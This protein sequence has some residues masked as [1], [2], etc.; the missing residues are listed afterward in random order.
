MYPIQMQSGKRGIGMGYEG[1]VKAFASVC[2]EHQREGRARA[3]AFV[4]Y[5]MNQGVVREALRDAHGFMRLHEK[6]GKD[7]TLF[8]LHDAAV[9]A[10]WQK[11]NLQF[12]KALGVEGQVST[13]CMVFFRVAGEI[14]EDV[15]IYSVDEKSVDPV[16]TVAELEGYVDTA[17]ANFNAQG[18][19]SPLGAP[20]KA[21]AK[22][23]GLIKVGEFLLKL[24][25][26]VGAG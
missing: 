7:V 13:P 18:G 4:F 17:I 15:S 11:F 14:I 22:I 3:F 12:M 21:A 6:T 5:D 8:Y 20:G 23:G 26:A 10:H 1:F 24:K 25:E 9:D 19:F 2:L 16:L